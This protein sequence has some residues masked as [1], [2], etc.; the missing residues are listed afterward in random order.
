MNQYNWF[1]STFKIGN[2]NNYV[3]GRLNDNIEAVGG[4]F[5][6]AKAFARASMEYNKRAVPD[7]I[8]RLGSMAKKPIWKND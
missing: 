2:F 6:S 3:L 5:Y 7:M 4:R 1:D 8:H